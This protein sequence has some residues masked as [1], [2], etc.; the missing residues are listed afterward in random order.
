[1]DDLKL[2]DRKTAQALMTILAFGLALL[3]LWAAWRALLT[4]LFAIFFAYLLE[5]PVSRL[6]GW[7][8]GSRMAAILAVYVVLIVGLTGIFSIAGPPVVQEGQ[9]LMQQAPQWASDIS[10][11]QIARS[12]GSQH[13][14]S[15]QTQQRIESF[16]LNHRQDV[17][18]TS[19][20][21]VLRAA[22]T[23]RNVWW[24]VLVPIFA[25]FFLK[26]GKKFGDLIIGSVRNQR[27]REIVAATMEEMNLM[28]AG[29]I[30]S[31]LVL[32]GMAVA[33]VTLVI[34]AMRVPYAFALGPAAG[35]LEFIPVAGPFVGGLLIV[36]VAVFSGYGHILWLMVFLLV[37]RGIQDYVSAPRIMGRELALHPLAVLFGVLAGGEVAGVIGV[38]LSIPV[39]AS[40]RIL[41]YTARRLYRKTQPHP[42]NA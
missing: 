40:I 31:Q 37:W 6:Q 21:L 28:L 42:E 38:F 2:F 8:R 4:F 7:L 30:R 29:F 3:F 1:L 27:N 26:D 15:T 9:R 35:V 24:L 13:G 41:W 17:I 22:K 25:I 10:S 32:A 19:Q 33:V 39:L 36:G 12:V 14:W 5:A 18:R 23:V 16:L 20:D 11:G 34:W